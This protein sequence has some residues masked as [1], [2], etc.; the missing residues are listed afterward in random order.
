MAG[1]YAK[2]VMF[3]A[4]LSAQ[5]GWVTALA[6]IAV[7]NAVIA[8]VYYARIAKVMWMDP[9]APGAA[10]LMSRPAPVGASLGLAIALSLIFVM[11]A[12]VLPQIA[13]FFGEASKALA[14][15]L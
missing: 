14:S 5:S 13:A 2:F 8:F 11:V 4:A 1:W 12:G 7:I 3:Q 9:V 10:S 6:V 15:G